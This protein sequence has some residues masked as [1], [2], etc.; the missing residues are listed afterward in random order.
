MFEYTTEKI[1]K[2]SMKRIGEAEHY[3]EAGFGW[4]L[5]MWL[6]WVAYMIFWL[7]G[8]NFLLTIFAG[9]VWIFSFWVFVYFAWKNFK[10]LKQVDKL[11]GKGK[12]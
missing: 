8:H 2:E 11:L 4:L 10:A 12:I 9:I 7:V 6:T 1:V 3:R 5:I